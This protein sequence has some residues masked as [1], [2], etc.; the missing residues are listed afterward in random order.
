MTNPDNYYVTLLFDEMY[1]I[2]QFWYICNKLIS[3]HSSKSV[4]PN[5]VAFDVASFQ[6]LV[7]CVCSNIRHFLSLLCVQKDEE[8]D[9]VLVK[10][11]EVEPVTRTQ[12]QTGLSIQEGEWTHPP[13]ISIRNPTMRYWLVKFSDITLSIK[14]ICLYSCLLPTC[15]SLLLFSKKNAPFLYSGKAD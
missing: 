12:S 11:E 13:F 3:A 10:V 7:L 15:T 9:V 6:S 8:P 1:S 14:Y 2:C 4:A 5:R